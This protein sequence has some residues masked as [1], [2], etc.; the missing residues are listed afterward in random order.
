MAL[1]AEVVVNLPD[2]PAL[3]RFHEP[4]LDQ[5][6]MWMV[7]RLLTAFPHMN[8]R[9]LIGWLRGIIQSHEFLFLFNQH[10]VGLAQ[11]IVPSPLRPDVAIQELFVFCED[12]KNSEHQRE[13]SEFYAET[14]RWAEGLGAKTVVVEVLSDVPHDMIRE[15]LG[16]LFEIKQIVARV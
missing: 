4:D 8:Q 12:P 6:G 2:I 7:P 11:M 14:K 3:R 5:H 9:G 13:A 16:R 15:K 1:P 10:S